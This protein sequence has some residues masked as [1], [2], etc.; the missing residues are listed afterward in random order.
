MLPGDIAQPGQSVFTISKNQ[1]LWITVYL[2]ETK[3]GEIHLGQDVVFTVDAFSGKK[4]HGKVF[5][6]GSNTASQFSLIPPS[7]A[8]GNFTKVTQR[9]PLKVSIDSLEDGGSTAGLNLLAGMSV[10][11]KI[12]R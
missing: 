5:F 11:I 7:N 6:I 9:V 4:F 1:Q 8:S 2:E 3:L 12:V 10:V